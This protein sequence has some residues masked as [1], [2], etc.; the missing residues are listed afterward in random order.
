MVGES[1]EI[2]QGAVIVGT[3]RVA[4]NRKDADDL[5]SMPHRHGHQRRRRTSGITEGNGVRIKLDRLFAKLQFRPAIEDAADSCGWP[6]RQPDRR[7][8]D[9]LAADRVDIQHGTD[10]I[11]V[12]IIEIDIACVPSEKLLRGYRNDQSRVELGAGAAQFSRQSRK[13]CAP[14]FGTL[15]VRYILGSAFKIE[16]GP[17]LVMHGSDI[18]G[19]PDTR[20]VFSTGFEFEIPY[21]PLH[22]KQTLE[23]IASLRV[24]IMLASNVSALRDQLFRRVKTHNASQR[25]VRR[26]ELA[27]RSAL[28]NTFTSVFENFAIFPLGFLQGPFG[29]VALSDVARIEYDAGHGWL[30]KQVG[31]RRFECAPSAVFVP[32]TQLFC[33]RDA[34]NLHCLRK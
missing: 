3:W 26:N 4:L 19:D 7:H 15:A 25:R 17:T 6:H 13:R 34:G 2:L 9:S 21:K 18:L 1:F 23:V 5:R 16:N 32:A 11:P 33:D 27:V 8:L 29:F 28:E 10:Q 31:G 24:D 30:M 20:S 12:F 14:H 22:L